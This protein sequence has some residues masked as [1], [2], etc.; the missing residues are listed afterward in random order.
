MGRH[1][2]STLC[3]RRAC[4]SKAKW[5]CRFG[6]LDEERLSQAPETLVGPE[7][8][9]LRCPAAVRVSGSVLLK[10]EPLL[11]ATHGPCSTAAPAA[12]GLARSGGTKTTGCQTTGLKRVGC[13]GQPVSVR[14]GSGELLVS[15]ALQLGRHQ[16]A[17]GG[18]AG[19]TRHGGHGGASRRHCHGP[20]FL[21]FVKVPR[22]PRSPSP[23][24][25]GAKCARELM[26]TLGWM[27]KISDFAEACG[28]QA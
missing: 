15:S 10:P 22:S 8:L 20:F 16:Q 9:G 4:A 14:R 23:S 24:A 1:R 3:R 18:L 26:H 21:F 28:K 2:G 13:A 7:R 25:V 17:T 11:P 6:Q 19:E 5:N 12:I 27:P